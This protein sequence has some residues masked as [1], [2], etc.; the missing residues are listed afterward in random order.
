MIYVRWSIR[1]SLSSLDFDHWLHPSDTLKMATRPKP[2]IAS[3][4]PMQCA[5]MTSRHGENDRYW[6][7]VGMQAVGINYYEW[8]K[9]CH[10]AQIDAFLTSWACAQSKEAIQDHWLV[11]NSTASAFGAYAITTKM[12]GVQVGTTEQSIRRARRQVR[13]WILLYSLHHRIRAIVQPEDSHTLYKKILLYCV[14]CYLSQNK[15][16]CWY[17]YLVISLSRL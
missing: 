2:D 6:R 1:I 8:S 11:D 16:L 15:S 14:T 10:H 4:W 12:Q 13:V 9:T 3:A 7:V 17:P 5:W